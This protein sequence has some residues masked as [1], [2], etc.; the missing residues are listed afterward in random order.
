MR[1]GGKKKKKA[2]SLSA[3]WIY[4][5]LSNLKLRELRFFSAN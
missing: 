1:M 4:S 5:I 2:S 3:Q